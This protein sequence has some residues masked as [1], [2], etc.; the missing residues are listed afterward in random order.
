MPSSPWPVPDIPDVDLAGFA[1]R[2]AARLADRPAL[3]GDRVMTYGELAER[4]ARAVV[5]EAVVKLRR[6]NG[7]ELV[8]E[9]LGALR[10]GAAVSP[11]SPLYTEREA[12]PQLAITRA[13]A[14]VALLLSS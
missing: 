6:P 1:L 10:A 14:D 2:H 11:I 3:I 5:D 12:A 8:V 7:P 4:V 13:D 9:L